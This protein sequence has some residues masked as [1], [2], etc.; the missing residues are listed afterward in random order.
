[1]D[2][3]FFFQMFDSLHAISK[4]QNFFFFSSFTIKMY[5]IITII[6]S[7]YSLSYDYLLGFISFTPP[8]KKK[9]KKQHFNDQQ[10]L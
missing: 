3:F 1:M 8:H 6:I 5:C 10:L 7:K 9:K 2:L 4:K